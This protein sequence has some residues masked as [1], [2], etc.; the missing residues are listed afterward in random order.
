[1]AMTCPNCGHTNPEGANFCESCGFNLKQS[2]PA[3]PPPST[4]SSPAIDPFATGQWT[5]PLGTGPGPAEPTL[6]MSGAVGMSTPSVPSAPEP[7]PMAAPPP[8][9]PVGGFSAPP[10][11]PPQ[12]FGPPPGEPASFGAPPPPSNPIGALPSVGAPPPV[13]STP[14]YG[15]PPPPVSP[16]TATGGGG[17]YGPPPSGF[18]GGPHPR[19]ANFGWI[20]EAW[21]LFSSDFGGWLGY[22]VVLVLVMMVL[23]GVLYFLA[24]APVI[25]GAAGGRGMQIGASIL[26]QM[27]SLL[28]FLVYVVAQGVLT[29]GI[30]SQLLKRLR[31]GT[32][33]DVK[34]TFTDGWSRVVPATLFSL[35]A[36]IVSACCCGLP[37]L[38]LMAPI[39]FT[40]FRL[41]DGAPDF[42]TAFK[43][44]LEVWQ[45]DPVGYIFWPI[46]MQLG[47]GLVAGLTC[48]LGAFVA[49]PV[50]LLAYTLAYRANFD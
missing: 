1:M 26:S 17:G 37:V 49:V 19:P 29:V 39:Y 38:V 40:Y 32:P 35:A 45:S 6:G 27:A 36:G 9:E 15:A 44:S 28:L 5:T 11:P 33:L 12:T 16:L 22:F 46:V 18:G 20:G 41:A 48:G 50:I 24:I 2:P 31:Y 34:G 10:P 7:I 30:A 21:T 13:S 3:S 43:E 42:V 4:G 14:S 25:A 23:F 47:A 8:L